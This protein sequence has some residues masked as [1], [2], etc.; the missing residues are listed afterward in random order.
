[1]WW[2][3]KN[4]PYQAIL[5]LSSIIGLVHYKK[6][7]KAFH[8]LIVYL[9]LTL[10]CEGLAVYS[11]I[12][13]KNNLPIYHTYSLVQYLLLSGYYISSV[14]DLNKPI[15]K[16]FVIIT[17]IAF[18]IVNT[19][20]IQHPLK[21]LNTHFIVFESFVIILLSLY[22]FYHLID[23]DDLNIRRNSHFWVTSLL[24]VFWSCTFFYWL[25]GVALYDSMINKPIWLDAMIMAINIL[26]YSGFG[27]I[28]LLYPKMKTK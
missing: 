10:F 9:W 1:M 2:I 7:D 21:E 19:S 14:K 25:V 18:T 26:T 6:M 12:V 4:I 24:L 5:L 22:S 3:Y 16:W 23:D 11:A 8:L 27:I 28:F 13:Y 15:L 17:G 20:F